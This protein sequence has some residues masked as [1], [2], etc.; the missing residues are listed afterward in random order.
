VPGFKIEPINIHARVK[1]TMAAQAAAPVTIKFTEEQKAAIE[2]AL[3][4]DELLV[5][6]VRDLIASGLALYQIP[7]PETRP[8]GGARPGAGRKKGDAKQIDKR[9]FDKG[10][11]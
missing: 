4:G 1:Q 6:K 9:D 8:H 2:T 7:W 10:A 11:G 5:E 3:P